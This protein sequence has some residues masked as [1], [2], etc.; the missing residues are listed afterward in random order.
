MR[1]VA[2]GAGAS[3]ISGGS[4][5]ICSGSIDPDYSITMSTRPPSTDIPG[6]TATCVTRPGLRRAQLVLHFHR[7]DHDHRLA[8]RHLI[9]LGDQDSHHTARHRRDDRLL[10]IGMYRGVGSAAPGTTSR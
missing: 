5:G 2:R 9:T 1:G 7:F 3:G 10:A 4:A 6:A 8:W